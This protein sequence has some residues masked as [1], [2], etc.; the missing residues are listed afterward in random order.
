MERFDGKNPI[1]RVWLFNGFVTVRRTK[2]LQPRLKRES[3]PATTMSSAFLVNKATTWYNPLR[4]GELRD[5]WGALS[6]AG[7][8]KWGLLQD[9]FFFPFIHLHLFFHSLPTIPLQYLNMISIRSLIILSVCSLAAAVPILEERADTKTGSMMLSYFGQQTGWWVF[10]LVGFLCDLILILLR[11][12]SPN[13]SKF[14]KSHLQT[15][16]Y[17]GIYH[18]SR[19]E[20]NQCGKW[21]TIKY[22]N[23]KAIHAKIIDSTDVSTLYWGRLS[24]FEPLLMLSFL[25]LWCAGEQQQYP[26]WKESLWTIRIGPS[27]KGRWCSMGFLQLLQQ[28][29]LPWWPLSE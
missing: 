11:C 2:R 18:A 10:Y 25:F 15:K 13:I 3:H 26:W 20:V 29:R 21:M 4:D 7:L 19:P 27:W 28:G 23:Q 22:D 9:C 14:T 16:S 1:L 12:N 6:I 17:V 5:G 24:D 8:Y